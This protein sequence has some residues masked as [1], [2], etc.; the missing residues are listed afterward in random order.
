MRTLAMSACVGLLALLSAAHASPVGGAFAKQIKQ[1][2]EVWKDTKIFRGGERASV[3]VVGKLP[4]LANMH[5][6]VFDAKGVLIAEDNGD[7]D[8]NGN[9]MSVSWYPPR[10]GTYTIEI[11]TTSS[12]GLLCYVTIK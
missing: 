3:Q 1:K 11:R 6:A 5:L 12:N 4:D 2:E 8:P 7:I 9:F 10:D